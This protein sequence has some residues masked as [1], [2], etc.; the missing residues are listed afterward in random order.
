MRRFSY[1]YMTRW[2]EEFRDGSPVPRGSPGQAVLSQRAVV[3]ETQRASE[4]EN[5]LATKLRRN[6]G[7]EQTRPKP[8]KGREP[9][10]KD[11]QFAILK[12]PG[13]GV[14]INKKTMV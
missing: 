2:Y 3:G 12:I 7:S 4:N 13:G 11:S 14:L 10:V 8:K 1:S 9:R 5:E 6:Y